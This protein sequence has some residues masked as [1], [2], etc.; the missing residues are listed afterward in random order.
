MIPRFG[1]AGNADSFYAAGF[2]S[3]L[4]APAWLQS[5]GLK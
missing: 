4:Q 5:L 3:S 2:K 1:P